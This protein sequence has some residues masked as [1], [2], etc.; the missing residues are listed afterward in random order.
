[1]L[2]IM[3]IIIVV[4][5]V[6]VVVVVIVIVV[7]IFIFTTTEVVCNFSFLEEM[8][9]DKHINVAYHFMVWYLETYKSTSC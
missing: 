8:L 5:V 9:W 3:K 7:V 6:V 1:M 2:A 4:V